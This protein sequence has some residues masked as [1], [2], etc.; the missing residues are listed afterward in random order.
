MFSLFE[1]K[2]LKGFEF[3]SDCKRLTLIGFIGLVLIRLIG[4]G[5]IHVAYSNKPKMPSKTKEG[6]AMLLTS[7]IVSYDTYSRHTPERQN[8][9]TCTICPRSLV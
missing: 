4:V 7:F 9:K 1:L 3:R 5:R 6:E 8:P 2:A